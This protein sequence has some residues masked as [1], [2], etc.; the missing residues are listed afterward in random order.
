MKN[1]CPPKL[2]DEQKKTIA[3]VFE[4]HRCPID[5]KKLE[6]IFAY[7]EDELDYAQ[8]EVPKR[9]S[10]SETL[11]EIKRLQHVLKGLNDHTKSILGHCCMDTLI[12]KQLNKTG[13]LDRLEIALCKTDEAND[14]MGITRMGF[15]CIPM[16]TEACAIAFMTGGR[17]L[18]GKKSVLDQLVT[19]RGHPYDTNAILL[20][21]LLADK[22]RLATGKIPSETPHG[23]F[24]DLVF[25]LLK[26]VFPNKRQY[27]RGGNCRK[28]IHVAL[29]P[30][31]AV[32]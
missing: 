21:R 20:V 25:T 28:L 7:I 32:F 23:L 17:P 29:G 26:I 11:A 15:A 22:Y 18:Y 3:C 8:D 13:L 5:Q 6:L 27:A 1:K 14:E 10:R 9:I 12:H 4:R 31:S 19:K 30:L 16:L 2:S 24:D